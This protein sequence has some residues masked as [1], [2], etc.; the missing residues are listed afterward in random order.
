MTTETTPAIDNLALN[1]S[2]TLREALEHYPAYRASLKSALLAALI[3]EAADTALNASSDN[4][5]N[6]L[7]QL[8]EAEPLARELLEADRNE[9]PAYWFF[10]EEGEIT[11]ETTIAAFGLLADMTFY[12]DDAW[13]RGIWEAR[14]N[15]AS[16]FF[17]VM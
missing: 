8:A 16:L 13:L 3:E 14:L 10:N 11:Q 7:H 5:I 6:M 12:G 1:A 2:L 17:M 4:I 9:P 15:A